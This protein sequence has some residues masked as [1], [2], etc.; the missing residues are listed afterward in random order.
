DFDNISYNDH[1][2]QIERLASAGIKV[3][4]IYTGYGY[5]DHILLDKPYEDK[6]LIAF[7][8]KL[9]LQKGFPV[10]QEIR[11]A[12]RIMRLPYTNNCKAFDPTLRNYYSPNPK[13]IP[14]EIV[15]ISST[16]YS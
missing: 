7:F 9:F 1:K 13:A 6:N 10:D 14:T 3:S 11:D 4:T 8:T 2:K 5:H 16:R 12:A 15:S